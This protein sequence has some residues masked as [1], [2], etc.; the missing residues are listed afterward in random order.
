VV[1]DERVVGY[2]DEL[3]D[4]EEYVAALASLIT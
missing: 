2:L 4:L 1:D 3:G